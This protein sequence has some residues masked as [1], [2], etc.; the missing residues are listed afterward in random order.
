[1]DQNTFAFV[2]ECFRV[3]SER[4]AV[5]LL[6]ECGSAF[7]SQ[8]WWEGEG[9]ASQRVARMLQRLAPA[10]VQA[11]MLARKAPASKA[12][13]AGKAGKGASERKGKPVQVYLG[14]ETPGE[15]A[16]K[17]FDGGFHAEE[18]AN[19]KMADDAGIPCACV[20]ERGKARVLH[21]ERA[22]LLVYGRR[23][24]KGESKQVGTRSGSG[25]WMKASSDRCS[26][27]KG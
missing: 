14:R 25:P 11:K 9:T 18:W 19:R 7:A 26:F 16:D 24:A 6:E 23:V 2:E 20:V 22:V 3:R 13:K 4:S 27:S 17:G 12:G 10:Y 21:R 15:K 5:A 1:M 8:P